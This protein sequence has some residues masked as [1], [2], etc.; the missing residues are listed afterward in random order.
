M[1]KTYTSSLFLPLLLLIGF[2]LL[3]LL[4]DGISSGFEFPG[5]SL[6][7][8]LY[9][10]ISTAIISFLIWVASIIS[11][12]GN[13]ITRRRL[14][15]FKEEYQFSDIVS[16]E[17]EKDSTSVYH[18]SVTYLAVVFQDGNRWHLHGFLNKKK[19][20]ID[21]IERIRKVRPETIDSRVES[22]LKKPC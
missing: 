8:L 6:R 20:I 13:K 1:K 10:V 16:V 7:L 15:I 18:G 2:P 17:P 19:D 11:V 9:L 4:A 5:R 3:S 14:L 21:L 12:N 22:Y